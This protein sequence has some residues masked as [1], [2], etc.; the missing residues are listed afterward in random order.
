M[1]GN[2]PYRGSGSSG[3]GK[4]WLWIATLIVVL[5]GL[6]IYFY[7]GSI[8]S[9]GPDEP[10]VQAPAAGTL[11]EAGEGDAE[12]NAIEQELNA[13]AIEGLDAE[14]GDIERELAQ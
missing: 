5:A 11:P 2:Q 3:G 9:P 6:V 4:K 7:S 14:L 13:T 8:T 10:S 12:A 1:N